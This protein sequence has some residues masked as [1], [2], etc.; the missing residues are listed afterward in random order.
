MQ[1]GIFEIF[2]SDSEWLPQLHCKPSCLTSLP[3][4]ICSVCGCN[5]DLFFGG[6][7]GQD[8]ALPTGFNSQAFLKKRS[9]ATNELVESMPMVCL[10]CLFTIF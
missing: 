5:T 1:A 6:G 9:R 8:N 4:A 2:C 7:G 3:I 10:Q